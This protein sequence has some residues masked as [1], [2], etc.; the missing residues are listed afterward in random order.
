MASDKQTMDLHTRRMVISANP[1]K[2]HKKQFYSWAQGNKNS[3][4]SGLFRILV[5]R[6][7]IGQVK[8][9]YFLLDVSSFHYFFNKRKHIVC[10]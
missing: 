4:T 2:G 5:A 8:G 6:G 7:G 9:R 10:P 1:I 3:P